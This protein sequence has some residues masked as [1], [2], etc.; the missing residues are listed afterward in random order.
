MGRFTA[1]EVAEGLRDGRI[2]PND[3]AWHEELTGWVPVSELRG[4]P[5]VP[6]MEAPAAGE[7]PVVPGSG[8]AA[9]EL[10]LEP[11]W[12]RRAQIGFV[13]AVVE[14][15]GGLL[16]R[17]TRT[18]SAMD[19][20]GSPLQAMWFLLLLGTAGSW[21]A[22]GFQYAVYKV[23]PEVF[24]EQMKEIPPGFFEA[25]FGAMVVVTPVWVAVSAVVFAGMIYAF[26]KLVVNAAPGYG[27][28]LRVHCYA[29]GAASVLQALPVCGGYLFPVVGIWLT[30]VGLRQTLRVPTGIAVAGALMPALLCCGAIFGLFAIALGTSGVR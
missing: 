19:P 24:G 17:P 7:A 16:G 30:V 4:L 23:N 1:E 8:P 27:G 9:P 18:F 20:G 15:L 14:S 21:V 11:A 29:W 22:V 13:A 2:F 3:L 12:E 10:P 28:V 6:P 25:A 5:E 26:L